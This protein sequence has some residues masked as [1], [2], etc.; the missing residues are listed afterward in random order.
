[1]CKTHTTY[2]GEYKPRTSCKKCWRMYITKHLDKVGKLLN[3]GV[4]F[5]GRNK[6]A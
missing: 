2:T 3:E 5:N 1:M 6:E 4:N